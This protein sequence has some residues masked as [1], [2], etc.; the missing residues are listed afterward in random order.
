[1]QMSSVACAMMVTSPSGLYHLKG[2]WPGSGLETQGHP[3][4]E[5]AE[6]VGLV[7]GGGGSILNV[8]VRGIAPLHDG[9][10]LKVVEPGVVI[11]DDTVRLGS[12]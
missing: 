8:E 11:V 6:E 5:E 2:R 7:D 12:G 4:T 3:S 9:R 10:S 1:M